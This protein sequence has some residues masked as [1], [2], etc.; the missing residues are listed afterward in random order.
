[1]TAK[2]R[3][4]DGKCVHC[5][6]SMSN[7][8]CTVHNFC[9][10][11]CWIFTCLKNRNEYEFVRVCVHQFDLMSYLVTIDIRR[12]KITFCICTH[13]TSLYCFPINVLLLLSMFWGHVYLTLPLFLSTVVILLPHSILEQQQK[14]SSIFDVVNAHSLHFPFSCRLYLLFISIDADDF[15]QRACCKATKQQ[16]RQKDPQPNADEW[17]RK[18]CTRREL[19]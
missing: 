3:A 9:L 7:F 6:S 15:G 18:K 17:N 16:Q 12:K 2:L 4:L 5:V 19:I 8:V 1:M 14:L 10:P 11:P 13:K